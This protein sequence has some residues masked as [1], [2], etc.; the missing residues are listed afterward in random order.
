MLR[1]HRRPSFV[2]EDARQHYK[3]C[4]FF[5]RSFSDVKAQLKHS[6]E[7]PPTLTELAAQGVRTPP[8]SSGAALNCSGAGSIVFNGESKTYNCAT[9][10]F[11]YARGS[12]GGS[13]RLGEQQ[14]IIAAHN[15]DYF[16]GGG[17][18][19]GT[20]IAENGRTLHLEPTKECP[21]A[22]K[23]EAQRIAAAVERSLSINVS[24]A[25]KQRQQTLAAQIN[26]IS[27]RVGIDPYL[28]HAV[29][30]AES[31]YK[32]NALSH[33]GAQGLMQLMPATAKRF[34]VSDPYH[35]GENIRGGATYLK[36]LL[37][38][39]NGNL[40]LAIA[41]YNAGEGNVRKYG[42]K[43][44]PFIETRAYVPKVLQYYRR[45]HDNP[46]EIGL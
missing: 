9:R 33:A 32:S 36:W 26:E 39:F 21:A 8:S 13:V 6:S 43:I 3:H 45:Y 42:Y 1:Q 19:G 23:I 25:F 12:T 10:S 5:S 34:G 35:T 18:C 31:A 11:D 22:F 7:N 41:G 17:S 20:I 14:A 38:E 37:N 44:P 29:I 2:S 24:G 28:V 16:S 4:T 40:E 46:K 30:S 15:L 27:A